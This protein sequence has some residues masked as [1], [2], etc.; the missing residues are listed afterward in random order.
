MSCIFIHGI[1]MMRNTTSAACLSKLAFLCCSDIPAWH[2]VVHVHSAP[3]NPSAF[4]GSCLNSYSSWIK[5][6][7]AHMPSKACIPPSCPPLLSVPLQDLTLLLLHLLRHLQAMMTY[8]ALQVSARERKRHH[9]RI[10]GLLKNS[11]EELGTL[12][13]ALHAVIDSVAACQ[14]VNVPVC[15]PSVP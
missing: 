9:A 5:K 8:T 10:V 14:G 4:C 11:F 12:A 1:G 6:F 3:P 13:Q 7:E 2:L 15:L